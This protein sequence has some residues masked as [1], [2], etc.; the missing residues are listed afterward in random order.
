MEVY[1]FKAFRFLRILSSFYKI[2]PHKLVIGNI[3]NKITYI[4]DKG[5]STISSGK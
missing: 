5:D 1:S 2:N 4:T 3:L